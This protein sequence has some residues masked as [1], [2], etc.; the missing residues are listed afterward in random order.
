MIRPCSNDLREDVV[1]AVEGGQPI[2]VAAK[3]FGVAVYWSSSG[4]SDIGQLAVSSRRKPVT[5]SCVMCLILRAARWL[6]GRWS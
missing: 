5:V 6:A 4:I 1:G 3:R 2:Y